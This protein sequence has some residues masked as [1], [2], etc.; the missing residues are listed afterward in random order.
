M[1]LPP[2][3]I[4]SFPFLG[5]VFPLL[6]S[7]SNVT[8]YK[9]ENPKRTINLETL[10]ENSEAFKFYTG[11]E[12]YNHFEYLLNFLGPA[13]DHLSYKS[14]LL[15]SSEELLLT[16]IK[17]RLNK[18]DQE[19]AF[20]FGVST[21]VVSQTFLTWLN[22]MYFTF[23]ELN[24]WP[25]KEIVE[26][27]MPFD[28]KEKFPS[29]RVILDATEIPIQKPSKVSAQSS[30]W[31]SYKNRNTVKC[32]IGITPKGLV[33]HISKAFGGSA[34]DRQII[35]NSDLLDEKKFEKKDSIM[36]DRGIMVQDLFASKDVFVNTP[37]TMRGKNQLEPKTVIK[38][39]RISSKRVHVER[40][41]GLAK[42][43]KI[44]KHELNHSYTKIAG[45]IVFVCFVLV[46]F[47]PNIVSKF[48]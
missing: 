17:L 15:S 45:R 35:E 43:F 41:I 37:T 33:S 34:S 32:M 44:L 11:F 46:N 27:F 21:H 7:H 26:T 9:Q 1:A 20:L 13:A 5:C 42:T 30:T 3:I 24:I 6:F 36:A 25:E 16:L 48:C 38:D 28:F 29:T 19:L 8:L 10:R 14:R 40:I 22:F 12:D 2:F 39:R 4:I 18:A 47:R 23:K 31:S